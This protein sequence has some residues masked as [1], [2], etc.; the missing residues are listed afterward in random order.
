MHPPSLGH[1]ELWR[2]GRR[3]PRYKGGVL[4]LNY[5]GEIWPPL[6]LHQHNSPV[7]RWRRYKLRMLLL[8][9]ATE[10]W[11]IETARL[12]RDY[13]GQPAQEERPAGR[14]SAG[15][16]AGAAVL[17][18]LNPQRHGRG[19]GTCTLKCT[20]FKPASCPIPNQHTPRNENKN[21]QPR[22]ESRS[23]VQ[24]ERLANYS[25]STWPW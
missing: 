12:R 15:A 9:Q 23:D 6:D 11:L 16:K 22:G 10:K 3:H 5:D 14:S 8:H 4:R 18:A 17:F 13:G 19:A 7:R 20:G 1:A 24:L 21:W 2:A 25:C